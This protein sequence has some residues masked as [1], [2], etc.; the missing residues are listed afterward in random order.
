[1][2]CDVLKGTQ[3][4]A[5]HINLAEG[6]YC[7]DLCTQGSVHIAG[8]PF[9]MKHGYCDTRDTTLSIRAA[10]ERILTLR[11]APYLTSDLEKC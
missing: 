9:K 8:T 4:L 2:G 3:A 5:L 11:D 10:I 6:I 7:H 1:M